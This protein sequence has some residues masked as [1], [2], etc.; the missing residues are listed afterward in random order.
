MYANQPSVAQQL[1]HEYTRDR[2]RSAEAARI[3]RRFR[4]ATRRGVDTTTAASSRRRVSL[5]TRTA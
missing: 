2:V 3:A 4:K 1:A 5:R